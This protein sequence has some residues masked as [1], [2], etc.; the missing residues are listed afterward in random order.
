MV[1]VLMTTH[2]AEDVKDGTLPNYQQEAINSTAKQVPKLKGVQF[3]NKN[4]WELEIPPNSVIYC[5]PLMRVQ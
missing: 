5:D 2:K 4:Y 3:E 1:D